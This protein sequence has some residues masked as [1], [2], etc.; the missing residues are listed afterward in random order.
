M[1]LPRL[2]VHFVASCGLPA[3]TSS[4]SGQLAPQTPGGEGR[5]MDLLSS[6]GLALSILVFCAVPAASWA[7]PWPRNQAVGT[8]HFTL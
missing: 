6:Q 4:V 5:C 1:N 2:I 3:L 7:E 8:A